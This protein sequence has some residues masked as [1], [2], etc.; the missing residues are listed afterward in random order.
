MQFLLS[1]GQWS[2]RVA[3]FTGLRR[4]F[5]QKNLEVAKKILNDS[6][7][8]EGKVAETYDKQ[9]AIRT[10]KCED[11][12]RT[13]TLLCYKSKTNNSECLF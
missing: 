6:V 5:K 8:V 7:N 2:L 12:L 11:C 3:P 9:L 1:V 13:S 4:G 10:L